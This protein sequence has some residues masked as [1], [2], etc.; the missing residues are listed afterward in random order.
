MAFCFADEPEIL[1]KSAITGSSMQT[2]LQQKIGSSLFL[3]L[4]LAAL[5][6]FFGLGAKQLWL[7]EI[8]QALHSS[9]NSIGGILD[10]VT[11]DRGGAPLDYVVQHT[12]IANLGVPI[13]WSARLHAA[14]FGVFSVLLVYLVCREIFSSERL[15]QLSALLFC[16][17]P[18]HI[19]YSQEGRPYS[20]FV[21]LTLLLYFLLFRLLKKNGR[22]LWVC[23]G[24]SAILAFYTHVYAAF[25]LFAQFVILI[26]Y[27]MLRKET[28]QKVLRRYAVFLICAGAAATAYVPWLLRSFFNARGEVAPEIGSR[29]FLE[30]I[31]RLGDGSFLLSAL[32]ILCAIA[33]IRHL[34]RTRQILGMGALLIWII[35]PLPMIM[36]LLTWR[37][38][39]FVPRQL[40]FI[41]P[42]FFMLVACGIEYFK[43][44]VSR[45]YFFPEIVIILISVGVIILHYRDDRDDI[46]GVAHLVRR[47][48][49]SSDLIVAPQLANYMCLYCP[50][51]DRYCANNRS[52]EDLIKAAQNGCRIIYISLQ[53]LDTDAVRLN[54]LLA[55][56]RKSREIRFRGI[57]VYY[58]IKQE[59]F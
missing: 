23:F 50:E 54:C 10:A 36:I 3:T 8:L 19:R 14:V 4:V 35:V 21:F 15:A 49:H 6:R 31:K 13:E 16:F 12:A 22:L 48:V 2:R 29:L 59:G 47:E 44:K 26:Y 34:V 51:I 42:A 57:A 9:P 53:R 38:Y 27:Q 18:F 58:F 30:T 24:M 46:R 55:G 37:S 1:Y 20:L 56:M 25:V 39:D 40:L 52:A 32:L 28:L 7:D 45:R 5:L 17:Y 41:T 33:G 11:L 43:Q